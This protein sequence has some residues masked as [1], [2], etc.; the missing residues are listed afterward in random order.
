[1]NKFFIGI[2][3]FFSTR[4]PLLF[5]TTLLLFLIFGFA[6]FQIDIEEDIT[7]MLPDD[8]K[9][10]KLNTAF[11][12]WRFIDKMTVVIS[13]NDT[14]AVP[15]PDSLIAKADSLVNR[16]NAKLGEYVSEVQFRLDDDFFLKLYNN[17]QSDLP[18]YLQP[19]D[20]ETIDS[21]IAPE[22]IKST[23]EYNY[24]LLTSPAGMAMKKMIASDPVGLTMIPV[25]RIR[26]AQRNENFEIYQ[27]CVFTKDKKNLLL[28]LY[29]SSP[30]NETGKNSAFIA[31][32]DREI[33]G[34]SKNPGLTIDYFG[35]PAIAVGNARQ[36]KR[37]TNITLSV[38]M[39]VL[40]VF[41]GF[42]FRSK[43]APFIMILP[44][45]FG[46][47]FSL[48]LIYLMQGT[49]SAVALGAGSVVLGIAVNYSLHV[50]SHYRHS[51]GMKEV[52]A[53]ISK[54][55]L[56][57]MITTVGS[58]LFLKVLKS[59]ILQ[60][61]GLFAGFALIG[62]ALFSILILPHL[63]PSS[64][65]AQDNKPR[66]KSFLD[67]LSVLRPERNTWL[68]AAIFAIT[69]V[70]LYFAT[71]VSFEGDMMKF[72][73]MS[74]KLRQSEQKI[75]SII[76]ETVNSSFIV[77][78]GSSLDEALMNNAALESKLDSLKQ[79][80]EV[81]NYSSISSL[82]ISKSQQ[83]ERITR[84]NDYWT[85]EKKEQ[86]KAALAEEGGQLKFKESAFQN[87][88]NLLDKQFAAGDPAEHAP[89]LSGFSDYIIEQTGFSAVITMV[90][91]EAENKKAVFDRLTQTENNFILDKQ[92][93]TNKFIELINNDFNLILG[94]TSLFVLFMLYATHA[95]V[96][97]AIVTF[98]PMLISW[99]WILGIMGMAEVN[100]NIVNI[101]LCTF[102]FGLGDDFSIFITEGLVQEY[103]EGKKNLSSIKVSNYLAAITIMLSL[104]ALIF[105]KHPALRSIAFTAV[106]G[107]FS[108]LVVSQ[109]LIPFFFKVLVTNRTAKGLRP[110]TIGGIF[111][112]V[113]AFT[114]FVAGSFI[115]T[116]LGFIALYLL[117]LGKEK[118][119][120]AF[121]FL[122]SWFVWGLVYLMVHVKK[123]YIGLEHTDFS[124]PAMIICNHQSFL[125][126]LVTVMTHPKLILLVNDWVYNSPVFGKVVKMADYYWVAEGADD[127]LEH[128]KD[129]V[130]NGYSIVV[131]P[132]GTRSPDGTIRRFH[133]GAFYLAE[134]LDLDIQPMLLHGTGD[135][136]KKGDF[137]L[138][139]G[140]MTMKFLP[141]IAQQDKTY[142]TTYSERT[143]TISRYFKQEYQKLKHEIETPE[144]FKSLLNSNYIYKGP[145][146]EWYIKVKVRLEN[147]YKLY[148]E[149]LP[150]N[151][152]IVDIGCGYGYA[153]YLLYFA[154]ND[155][156]ITAVDFDAEKIKV[157]QNCFSANPNVEFICADVRTFQPPKADAFII[158]DVLH[159]L[160]SED[161]DALISKCIEKL[162]E[163]GKIFIKEA[164]ADIKER[165]KMTKLTEV[166]STNSGFNIK[167]KEGLHFVSA[168]KIK[169]VAAKY[170]YKVKVAEESQYTS[171]KILIISKHSL[172]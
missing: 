156:Q 136:M 53:E 118:R 163:N 147:Y 115:L 17:I 1:M 47:T 130:K 56:I 100:F 150:Y 43:R 157:A 145:V 54:P 13:A 152:K 129:R 148:H 32:L 31:G 76:S 82:L 15:E 109:T 79:N 85:N 22:K 93:I 139:G 69:I 30:A 126:I 7:K 113:V 169:S 46:V 78:T 172:A 140:P 162:N 107:L 72:N 12:N 116:I 170:G 141:R 62:A 20:Y 5:A 96:E 88:Y 18:I 70:L 133:K 41:I 166:I 66:R 59:Q 27:G 168:E 67:K 135:R 44:V 4:K 63:I 102:I 98:I 48:G 123:R 50:F 117:P 121:H 19:G 86:L 73:Y 74:K 127:S 83:Q 80:G 164:D 60:D 55:M 49:I 2:Y 154:G 25:S 122:L 24:K 143:K 8:P 165:H 16:V 58:F 106:I 138:T 142:G 144:Y 23:L 158:S 95:R 57:G 131:F 26:D 103:K 45:V 37:D 114:Y 77:T 110:Y 134:K 137:L 91:T 146:I 6:A 42:F 125:D 124:R 40:I 167:G 94:F 84:W 155:R 101:I 51:T 68:I 153:D 120:Y 64:F 36:I 21:L 14:S 33:A 161:Q 97:L 9:L 99:V 159:Y 132:E 3:T 92:L 81:K 128:L 149:Q 171:N 160:Q 119:K 108:V 151:C 105:A 87:F 89:M 11:K 61:F 52:I 112:S 38:T 29:A 28:F 90:R 75:N 65:A 34:L 10:G 71:R 39:L 104:G 111:M 35:T